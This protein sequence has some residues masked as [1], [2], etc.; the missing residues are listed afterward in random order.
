MRTPSE[1][2]VDNYYG[3]M[4]H[5]ARS[6][7][8][9]KEA[10]EDVVQETFLGVINGIDR[11]EERSSLRT[12]MFRILVNRAKTRGQRDGRTRPFSSLTDGLDDD[13][14]AVDR[15]LH[16]GRWAGFWSAPPSAEHVPDASV[17]AAELG[18][19]LAAAVSAPPPAQRTVLEL[20]DVQGF[21]AAEVCELLDV[22]EVN[23]RVLLHAPGA[24]R[25]LLEAIWTNGRGSAD[26]SARDPLRR[27]RR[28]RHR[29]DGRRSPTTT[30]WRSRSTS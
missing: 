7:V 12:W 20:R 26:A 22:S 27:V 23:Q 16:D 18:D 10:A 17:L 15:F 13:E 5:I 28:V 30:G 3:L 19:R 14:A 21:S 8:A 1:Q 25:A 11:F 29:L 24:R 2:L 4:L 9:T 6:F